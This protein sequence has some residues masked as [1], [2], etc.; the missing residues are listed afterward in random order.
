[1]KERYCRQWF[2]LLVLGTV[3]C[4]S[5][6]AVLK[7]AM[8][9]DS[10]ATMAVTIDEPGDHLGAILERL[11]AGT[12]VRLEAATPM[13]DTALVCRYVG[14]L[15]GFLDALAAFFAADREHKPRW[16]RSGPPDHARFRLERDLATVQVVERL[17]RDRESDLVQ[18]M[19]GML[20]VPTMTADDW[21]NL[22]RTDPRLAAALKGARTYAMGSKAL[23]QFGQLPAEQRRQVYAG[24]RVTLL[25]AALAGRR[26]PG[27]QMRDLVGG[28]A[29]KWSGQGRITYSMAGPGP[30]QRSFCWTLEGDPEH[31]NI[32]CAGG[33]CVT[34]IFPDLAADRQVIDWR[35]R[36]GDPW[37]QDTAKVR[38]MLPGD[39]Q[40]DLMRRRDVLL[41]IA[42]RA[43]INLIA[44]EAGRSLEAQMFPPTGTVAQLLDHACHLQP[45]LGEWETENHGSFW[46]KAGDSYLVRS[47]SW[48]EEEVHLIPYRWV[49]TWRESEKKNGRLTLEDVLAM[50]ALHP[51][52]LV[53][54]ALWYPQADRIAKAQGPLRW[55]S[56]AAPNLKAR[57]AKPPGLPL[58]MLG[59][60]ADQLTPELDPMNPREEYA[61][62]VQD[63]GPEK[64]NFFVTVGEVKVNK[65]WRKNVLGVCFAEYRGE[66]KPYRAFTLAIPLTRETLPPP[67]PASQPP[68]G[69]HR[70]P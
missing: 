9:G 38:F 22:S 42:H 40:P 45:R 53:Q 55:Y 67:S 57:L 39:P 8:E 50:A 30:L 28:D 32:G 25:L 62:M 69:P 47:L 43:S 6:A 35:Q 37:P 7:R 56:R 58:A 52:Q 24:G 16:L 41:R 65:V 15:A 46:R 27:E 2:L 60:D 33:S 54:L 10:R 29:T 51:Q 17:R 44:D 61:T 68:A 23:Q 12:G 49:K 13:A 5:N 64:L 11:S 19:E 31:P 26:S 4:P 70:R 1:M 20:R 66:T 21:Q 63:I 3:C 18:R 59:V 48:P 34:Q 36:Y 14:T